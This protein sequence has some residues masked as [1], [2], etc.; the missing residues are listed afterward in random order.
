MP[1]REPRIVAF[2]F[3]FETTTKEVS[4]KLQRLEDAILEILCPDENEHPECEDGE[5][6]PIVSMS[7][8][9]YNDVEQYMV[10]F[11]HK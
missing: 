4:E 7:S 11:I 2:E 3:A 9:V 1:R 5:P 8:I 10:Q 6:C